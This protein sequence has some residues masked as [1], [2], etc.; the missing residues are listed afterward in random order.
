VARSANRTLSIESIVKALLEEGVDPRPIARAL[1]LD[2]A[3]VVGLPIERKR[4]VSDEEELTSQVQQLL[5]MA[6]EEAFKLLTEGTPAVKT[7]F[8]QTLISPFLRN[9]S[10]QTPRELENMRDE[11]LSMFAGQRAVGNGS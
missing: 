9:T 11:V 2:M 10:Q 6:L 3:W 4:R 7:R 5:S 8:I 1:S